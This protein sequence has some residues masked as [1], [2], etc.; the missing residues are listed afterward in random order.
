MQL[1]LKKFNEENPNVILVDFRHSMLVEVNTM[2]KIE[3][4]KATVDALISE[5]IRE[6]VA[7]VIA[8]NSLRRLKWGK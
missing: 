5:G 2:I 1:D 7:V 6:S 8:K 3:G 4:F